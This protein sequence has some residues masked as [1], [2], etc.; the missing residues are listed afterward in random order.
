MNEHDIAHWEYLKKKR[1]DLRYVVYVT[2]SLSMGVTAAFR[3]IEDAKSFCDGPMCAGGNGRPAGSVT[4][5]DT[6]LQIWPEPQPWWPSE[7]R[8]TAEEIDRV[9]DGDDA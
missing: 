4:D 6:G 7:R 2:D 5:T 9:H 1:S 8:K 3:D